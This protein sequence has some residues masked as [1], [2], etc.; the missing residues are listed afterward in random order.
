MSQIHS[1]EE[2]KL[3]SI[4]KKGEDVLEKQQPQSKTSF[5][6]ELDGDDEA[7]VSISSKKNTAFC[8]CNE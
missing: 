2:A 3:H 6:P 4:W 1:P 8:F 7:D 5:K